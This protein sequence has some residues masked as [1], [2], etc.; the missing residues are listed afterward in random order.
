MFTTVEQL[1]RV[2]PERENFRKGFSMSMLASVCVTCE[3]VLGI[4][5]GCSCSW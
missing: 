2:V 3:G 1:G 4:K 5:I